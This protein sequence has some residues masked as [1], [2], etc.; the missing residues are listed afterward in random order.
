MQSED[1]AAVLQAV[2]TLTDE[3]RVLRQAVD[4]LTSEVQFANNNSDGAHNAP[5]H[6]GPP[7][8]LHSMSK[9]AAASDWTINAVDESTVDRLRSQ[10]LAA[11]KDADQQELF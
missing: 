1:V 5:A 7:F 8:R 11:G 3:L 10:L 2:E 4:D 9:D 6:F